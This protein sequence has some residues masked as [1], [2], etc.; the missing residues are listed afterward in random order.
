MNLIDFDIKFNS[1]LLACRQLRS[2]YMQESGTWQDSL[3]IKEMHRFILIYNQSFNS[4][5]A[6]A[7]VDKRNG[8]VLKP[9]SWKAPAKHP[10]GNIFDSNNGMGMITAWGP[11]YLN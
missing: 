6:W 11:K 1:W 5:S 9:A 4:K 10:R 3:E 2:K 8:D 7:F